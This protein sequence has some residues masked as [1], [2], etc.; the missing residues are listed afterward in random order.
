MLNCPP[1]RYRNLS[2]SSISSPK[3][4]SATDS[5]KTSFNYQHQIAGHSPNLRTKM[6]TA[7]VSYRQPSQFHGS[8]DSILQ[9]L[10]R[11]AYLD[12]LISFERDQCFGSLECFWGAQLWRCCWFGGRI[13]AAVWIGLSK[14][15]HHPDYPFSNQRPMSCRSSNSLLLNP[16]PSDD[17]HTARVDHPLIEVAAQFC[18]GSSE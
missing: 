3:L 7:S 17:H 2:W 1:F 18:Y 14:I 6:T 4:S 13:C 5:P 8:F 11:K 10:A 15:A 16:S 12:H 9:F